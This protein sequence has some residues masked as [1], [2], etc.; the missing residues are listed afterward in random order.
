MSGLVC[1]I[2][3]ASRALIS[4]P[5]A[6]SKWNQIGPAG[7]VTLKRKKISRA[8]AQQIHSIAPIS[9]NKYVKPLNEYKWNDYLG[10]MVT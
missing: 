3:F 4:Q 2:K 6:L 8:T 9:P 5:L 1:R 10:L 7:E